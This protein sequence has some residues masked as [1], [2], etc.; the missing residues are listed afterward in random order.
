MI[1]NN[2]LIKL[3][4]SQPLDIRINLINCLLD[5]INPYQKEITE[6]WCN[7]VENRLKDIKSGK[8]KTIPGEEVFKLIKEKYYQ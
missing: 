8:T 1:N 7:E 6:M 3:A 5:S 4:V 2:E